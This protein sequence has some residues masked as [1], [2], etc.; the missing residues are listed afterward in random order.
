M[1]CVAWY[2]GTHL[3]SF[4]QF[5]IGCGQL[6]V[7]PLLLMLHD[8]QPAH[9]VFLLTLSIQLNLC[10]LG[11]GDGGSVILGDGGSVIV[12]DGGV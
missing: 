11:V 3:H 9:Q 10:Y 7:G 2:G 4:L 8:H 5:P 12:G 1:H 6:I